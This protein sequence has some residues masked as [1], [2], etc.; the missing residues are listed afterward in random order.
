MSDVPAP[1]PPRKGNPLSRPSKRDPNNLNKNDRGHLSKAVLP[2]TPGHP[3]RDYE[4]MHIG[5]SLY[6]RELA[7]QVCD[8][9]MAGKS[10]AEIEREFGLGKSTINK[11]AVQGFDDFASR[12]VQAR[13]IGAYALADELL[14]IADDGRNDWMK[15]KDPGNPGYVL[16]GENVRRSELRIKTRQ[17]T[18]ERILHR[19]FGQ[20]IQSESNVNVTLTALVARSMSMTIDEV[21]DAVVDGEEP[22]T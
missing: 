18:L 21:K 10:L 2:G 3:V 16:N 7:D 19:V 17:W 13:E 22:N 11:W 8:R 1:T 6:T 12:L 5:K 15:S 20:K 9:V 4:I 14:E